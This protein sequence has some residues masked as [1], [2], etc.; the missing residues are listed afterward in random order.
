MSSDKNGDSLQYK[1]TLVSK[2]SASSAVLTFD[3]T[4]KPTFTLDA[5]G[6][7]SVALIVNDG[8]ASSLPSTV[9]VSALATPSS[10]NAAPFA[11]AGLDQTVTIGA[12]VNLDGSLSSDP[13]GDSLSYVWSLTIKPANSTAQITAPTISKPQFIPDIAGIYEVSLVV[14]DGKLKSL[15]ADKIN[16]VAM[17]K[18]APVILDS[19]LYRCSN[20]TKERAVLLYS[21]GHTYLDRD[22]DGLPCEAND[23][24]NEI[25]SPYIVPTPP[26]TGLC[27][28]NGYYRKSGT[29]VKGYFRKC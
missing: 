10:V 12:G 18:S 3:T 27:Y 11:N 28:V 5:V 13:N 14:S 4:I 21:Q 1:W 19:G 29:Y 25:T 26:S 7:Y 8:K 2:P 24:A 16:I 20:I 9:L 23:I 17:A 6:V 15:N 22:H